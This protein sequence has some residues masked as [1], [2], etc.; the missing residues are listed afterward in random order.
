MLRL[1]S[2]DLIMWC[3]L[4]VRAAVCS[5]GSAW[6]GTCRGTWMGGRGNGGDAVWVLF[7]P[8]FKRLLRCGCGHGTRYIHVR[9]CIDRDQNGEVSAVS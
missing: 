8:A 9:T 4:C 2:T 1:E 3:L 5:C 7:D 6:L